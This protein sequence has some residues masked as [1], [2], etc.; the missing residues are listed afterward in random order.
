MSVT[1]YWVPKEFLSRWGKFIDDVPQDESVILAADH[2]RAV[3]ALERELRKWQQPFDREAFEHI[4]NQASHKDSLAAQGIYIIAI[5]HALKHAQAAV[6]RESAKIASEGSQALR[7]A[8]HLNKADALA[9]LATVFEARA[10]AEDAN[11]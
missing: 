7:S 3:E 2:T 4:K 5:E 10:A 1:R 9:S 8:G 6:W 11:G